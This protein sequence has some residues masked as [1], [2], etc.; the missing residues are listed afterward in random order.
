MPGRVRE[1]RD[2]YV[3]TLG[4]MCGA[5]C[6]CREP[7]WTEAAAVGSLSWIE[8]L[9]KSVVIGHKQVIPLESAVAAAVGEEERSYALKLS[10]HQCRKLWQP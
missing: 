2:W 9:A 10:P 7:H 8:S 3:S 4:R 1:F 6:L 5:R